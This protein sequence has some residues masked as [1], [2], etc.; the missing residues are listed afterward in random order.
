MVGV[1][2]DQVVLV[3][4]KNV[5][6]RWTLVALGLAIGYI[7][8]YKPGAGLQHVTSVMWISALGI[9]YKL[10]VTGLNVFLVGLTTLLFFASTLACNLRS[11]APSSAPGSSTSSS[12]WPSRP[13]SV[14][15]SPRT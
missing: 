5:I 2:N 9:H 6:G 3:P 12:C 10:A 8:D 4:F 7:A 1:Q 14:P 13:S 15:S 11:S